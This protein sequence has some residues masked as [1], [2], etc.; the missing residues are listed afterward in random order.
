MD[1]AKLKLATTVEH[2]LYDGEKVEC[3]LAMYRLKLLASKN[4]AL[5]KTALKVISKGAEDVFEQTKAVYA[6]YVC[7]N[8]NSENLMSEEEFFEA[9][10]SDYVGLSHTLSRLINPKNRQASGNRSNAKQAAGSE[11]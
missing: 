5:Y 2:E 1:N 6:A 9:C 10:G 3:T 8:M 11:A 4:K 7:A